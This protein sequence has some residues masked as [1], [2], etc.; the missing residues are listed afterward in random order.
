MYA[1]T[2]RSRS[3][4]AG[5]LCLALL[6]GCGGGATPA[7]RPPSPVTQVSTS[8]STISLS[9]DVAEATPAP[10]II[11]VSVAN[12][13]TADLA[14]KVVWSGTAVTSASFT[15]QSSAKGELSV[16]VPNPAQLGAGTYQGTVVLSICSD[17]AC[18][19]NVSGSPVT[20]SVTYTV[21]A[22]GSA[23]ATFSVQ[24]Q[25]T[26]FETHTAD[27]APAAAFNVYLQH[28]P[29]AGLFI[30][31]IQPTTGFI[32]ALSHTQSVDTSGQITVA[33]SLTLV[34]PATLGSGFFHSSVTFKV[35]LDKACQHQLAGSP[36]TEPIDY[37]VYLTEGHE[38]SLR[39]IGAGGIS[40]LA[41][42]AVGQKL[43]LSGL[44]G[45]G[46]SYSGAVS[47]VDPRTGSLG[48]QLPLADDLFGVATSDDGSYVYVGSITN[49]VVHRLKLPS[50]A[51]DLDIALGSG[52]NIVSELTV[53]P[54]A[55]HTLVVSLTHPH[56]VT[57][58]G[59]VIF[60][61]A[62]ARAQSLPP[63]GYYS[64]PDALA[65]GSS[66]TTLYVSRYSSQQ[67]LEISIASVALGSNGLNIASSLSVDASKYA[68][69]RAFYGAGRVYDIFGHVL[70]ASTG[71]ALGQFLF[72]VSDYIVTLLPDLSHGRVF[73]LQPDGRINRLFL[74]S[75]DASTFALQSVV[76]LGY[77]SFDVALT[78]H[79]IAWGTDGIAFN[80][81]G[82]QILAGSFSAPPTTT[83]TV[84]TMLHAPTPDFAAQP[85]R[86]VN[87]GWR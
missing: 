10:A 49:P 26:G 41:Y 34:T 2:T 22:N 29:A 75:Y 9:A 46:S 47:Q 84:R 18:T 71:A 68:F 13:P 60:D 74:L 27:P 12:A 25:L 45:Y 39:T 17:G 54:G 85:I 15:W 19:Q 62:V 76:N 81:N 51:A 44:S 33:I 40:D 79:L 42:D 77:D 6:N 4:A 32:T 31:P 37:T 7:S 8:A 14:S 65:W 86:V 1:D 57:T 36:A 30:L 20:M 67:P 80:R 38:Y 11:Q 28:V 73:V 82:V 63:I 50:L 58:A 70:D 5:F 52:P 56:S 21:T 16:V 66:A 78:T 61:D 64:E 59:T 24:S 23:P 35:C 55:P 48:A 43:Y 87:P 69:G 83:A 3:F 72:P 53:A